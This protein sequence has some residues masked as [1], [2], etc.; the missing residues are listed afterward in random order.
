MSKIFKNVKFSFMI[1]G[2]NCSCPIHATVS[3]VYTNLFINCDQDIG[4]TAGGGL[5]CSNDVHALNCRYSRLSTP[6]NNSCKLSV[7]HANCQSEMNK[8]SE[9][10]GL[11]DSQNPHILAL[12]EFGAAT[13]VGDGELGIEGYSY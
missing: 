6:H 13:D 4:N 2:N 1:F 7:I 9:V 3:F 11:I 10:C 12:T 8:Q 5:S